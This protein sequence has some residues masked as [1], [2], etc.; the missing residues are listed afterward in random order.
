[1]L[2]AIWHF[3]A[4]FCDWLSM[5]QAD[6]FGELFVSVSCVRMAANI[7]VLANGMAAGVIGSKSTRMGL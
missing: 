6:E 3:D 1:M 2:D 5:C 7:G 4:E